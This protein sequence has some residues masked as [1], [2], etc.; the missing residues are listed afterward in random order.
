VDSAEYIYTPSHKW[1]EL[2]AYTFEKLTQLEG[3]A[4]NETGIMFV[5]NEDNYANLS[6][7]GANPWFRSLVK[8]VSKRGGLVRQVANSLF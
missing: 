7:K 8:N 5:D 3:E 2:D 6:Q 4:G 1:L